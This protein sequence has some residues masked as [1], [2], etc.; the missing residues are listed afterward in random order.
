[1]RKL[2]EKLLL[3]SNVAIFWAYGIGF[4]AAPRALGEQLGIQLTNATALADF[5]AMYSGLCLACGFVFFRGL[6]DA[7]W[8][9]PALWLA[10]LSAAGLALGRVATLVLDGVTSPIILGFL[11]SEVVAVVAGAYVLMGPLT[12]AAA[13][14]LAAAP[15]R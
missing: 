10:T 9:V 7:T 2:T 8:R 15:P 13:S 4:L 6:R 12:P 11:G 14:T 5:R 3:A 1:M